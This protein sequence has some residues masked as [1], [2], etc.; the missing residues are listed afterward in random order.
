MNNLKILTTIVFWCLA[1]S[2][3][4]V[5][6]NK[7]SPDAS[8]TY[9]SD[10][11]AARRFVERTVTG[12]VVGVHD[13]DTVTVLNA[14]KTQYKFRLGGID[15]PELKTDFGNRS[16]KN[17][18]ERI[19]GK[20]VKVEYSKIDK[21]GRYIGTVF[22]DGE[23]VNLEQIESGSA[24]HYKKYADEQ[25]P[26]DRKVYA[27]AETKARDAKLGIWSLPNPVPPWNYR[28]DLKAKQRQ[29]RKNREYFIGSRGG[30]Y[31]IAS[32]GKKLYVAKKFCAGIRIAP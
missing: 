11:S 30:C 5:A 7:A 14:N 26:E 19:F 22:I 13:G 18:S 6:Q 23:D 28:A 12:K 1:F 27:K 15:A 31:Y 24:W 25:S 32:S 10:L 16:K 17:L 20:T 8:D 21:Y 2:L 3:S 29:S 4:T 9:S